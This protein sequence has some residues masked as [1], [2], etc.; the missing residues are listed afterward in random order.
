MTV[1]DKCKQ[2]KDIFPEYQDNQYYKN[3]LTYYKEEI[4]RSTQ[5]E[6]IYK[7]ATFLKVADS[8]QDAMSMLAAIDLLEEVKG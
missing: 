2:L 7:V 5:T 3:Q 8:H 4:E 1:Y 6:K